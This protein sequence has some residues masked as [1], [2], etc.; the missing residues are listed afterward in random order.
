MDRL[1][2]SGELV[3]DNDTA[4]LLVGMS[5]AAIDRRLAPERKKHQLKGRSRT[6]PGSLLKS[7]IPIRTW[8]DWDDGSEFINYH[9]LAWCEQRK[10]TFTTFTRLRSGSSNDGCH[11][12]Q[13]NWAV[14]RIVVGYHRYDT[15]A[16]LLLL[17]KIWALQSQLTNYF[18]SQQKLVSKVCHGAKMTK[19]Y[20]TATTPHRRA[21]RHE[22][23]SAEHKTILTDTYAGINP[24]AVQRHIQA[25]TTELLAITTS[26]A[27]PKAKAPVH[28]APTRA[29]ADEATSQSPR[30]T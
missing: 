5:A 10:I 1:R 19:K 11:I 4:A 22:A 23:V 30:A 12:E 20:D 2:R 7:Q 6:K 26:K 24:T 17:N 29:S 16:E 18:Y 21:E 28:T 14:V 27:R 3:I 25:L 13:K 8:A 15:P 9:L